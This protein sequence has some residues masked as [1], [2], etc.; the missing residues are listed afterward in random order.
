MAVTSMDRGQY[1]V[2]GARGNTYT[3]DLE[4][5]LCTCPDH[6][7]RGG[8]CKHLRRVAIEINEGLVPPPGRVRDRCAACGAETFVDAEA[9]V[10]LCLS[11]HVEPVDPVRDRETELPENG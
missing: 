4:D 7:F 5:S 11:C 6:T 2:E 3:V 1:V 8:R 10:P 9:S